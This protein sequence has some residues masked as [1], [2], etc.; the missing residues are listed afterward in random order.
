V[1]RRSRSDGAPKGYLA[2]LV[3]GERERGG[4]VRL[5][6]RPMFE[7]GLPHV[8]EVEAPA[9]LG[10]PAYAG[11]RATPPTVAAPSVPEP[12]PW[13]RAEATRTTSE[14][15]DLPRAEPRGARS[16]DG[17]APGADP[18]RRVDPDGSALTR[19]PAPR[20]YSPWPARDRDTGRRVR[21][22]PERSAPEPERRRLAHPDPGRGTATDTGRP[23]R[24]ATTEA[25]GPRPRPAAEPPPDRSRD[26]AE[27]ATVLVSIGRIEVRAV[28]PV[29]ALPAAQLPP[30]Q[31]PALS[32]EDYLRSREARR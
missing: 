19:P 23:E 24:A 21:S 17:A 10:M 26:D 3:Q 11:D 27:P 5:R 9:P 15:I 25:Q 7:R 29:A 1:P 32:L 16:S 31:R 20:A 8:E 6:P 28:T 18:Y 30:R 2:I 14:A 12:R 22:T 13:Q 4:G